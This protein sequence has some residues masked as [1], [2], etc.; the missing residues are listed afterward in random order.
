MDYASEI[1]PICKRSLSKFCKKNPVLRKVLTNKIN[2]ILSNPFHY[3]P[4]S[5]DFSGE[6]RVHILKS[7]V[8]VFRIDHIRRIV[9]FIRFRHHDKAY[10]R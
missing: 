1:K 2:E 10:K 5:H 6:R 4:L 3:K 8:L 9:I 7:Y